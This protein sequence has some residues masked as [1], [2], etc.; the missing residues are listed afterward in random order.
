MKIVLKTLLYLLL[1]LGA[2][3]ASLY[4]GNF[5]VNDPG[6]VIISYSGQAV[7]ITFAKFVI[8]LLFLFLA[9]YIVLRLLLRLLNSPKAWRRWRR[10]RRRG[11][12]RKALWRGLV[13][14][15][16]GDWERAERS[17]IGHAADSD[18]ALLH[19]LGAA[20]A[21]QAQGAVERRDAYLRL[22]REVEPD[23]RAAVGLS[24]AEMQLGQGQV[25]QARATL[26]ELLEQEP[27]NRRA[28][29]L[30]YEILRQSEA[31]NDLMPLLPRLR[32][33]QV[34]AED[35][36]ET[37]ARRAYQG[38]LEGP[39]SR[40]EEIWQQVPRRYRKDP[41]F[42]LSYCDALVREQ[43]I[44]E[45]EALLRNYLD[46]HWDAALATRY[47]QL[48]PADPGAQLR[49]AEAWL[50]SHGEQPAL[51][52]TL[53]RL[54]MRQQLWGKARGYFEQALEREPSPEVYAL[55]VETLNQSGEP[56][57]AGACA[58]AALARLSGVTGTA[59][60]RAPQPAAQPAAGSEET[61]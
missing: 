34:L 33:R 60:A 19:Y 16:A 11:R 42:L 56:E 35:E 20:R 29:R 7:S 8:L 14:L 49:R 9:T 58:Q 36:L 24:R 21:A 31:W 47:G 3:I 6:E 40:A 1:V 41:G 50:A 18:M 27:G 61:R 25:E 48:E 15:A 43:R 57:A 2:L 13:D 32:R 53:G 26:T 28:L 30:L 52:V 59:L 4:I 54:C 45:A 23:A 51:L 44:G 22:A 12:A 46:R 38:L 37:I 39:Q 5:L 55:L 10:G 17:L